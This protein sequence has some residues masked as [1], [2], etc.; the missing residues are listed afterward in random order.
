[1]LAHPFRGLE[2]WNITTG[3]RV[4]EDSRIYAASIAMD[5]HRNR[6]AVAEANSAI[7]LKEADTGR[8][9]DI[10]S[11][12]SGYRTVTSDQTGKFVAAG[13]SGGTVALLD[14]AD[15]S[16]DRQIPVAKPGALR[17]TVLSPDGTWV[18]AGL[19]D[20]SITLRSTSDDA[21]ICRFTMPGAVVAMATAQREQTT[22]LAACAVASTRV[23]AVGRSDRPLLDINGHVEIQA[24]DLSADG[25]LLAISAIG[26]AIRVA[27]IPM[28]E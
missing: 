3:A 12:G 5:A 8:D 16:M 18:A 22:L 10:A 1:M 14:A 11:F 13:T 28:D 23:W 26:G 20:G 6:L 15:L 4:W 19:I 7:R 2:L 17:C 21:D 24:L 27:P 25:Q 9:L